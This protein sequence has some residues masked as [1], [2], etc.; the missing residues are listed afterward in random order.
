M[1]APLVQA[2][3]SLWAL[4]LAIPSATFSAEC[5][6]GVLGGR[7]RHAPTRDESAKTTILI[8]AHNESAGIGETLAKLSA[9]LRRS[10]QILVVAD[11]CTDDTAAK[12]RLAGA[13]VLERVDPERR[14]KGYALS[15]GVAHMASLPS[16]PNIVLVMDA[17]C[18]LSEGGIDALA[19]TALS[20]NR[21]AQAEYAMVIPEGADLKTKIGAF[22]FRVKNLIRPRALHCLGLGRQLAG[23]GMAFPWSVL[24]DAPDM[25]GHITEDLVL[26]LELALRG[27]A[28]VHCPD[29]LVESD[30]AP[31]VSGQAGQRKRWEQGH[32]LAIREYLPK[33]L[34]GALRQRRVEL[35]VLGC[36][37][38][39]PS[40]AI[41]VLMLG[42]TCA[43]TGALAAAWPA[44]GL[45]PFSIGC[46]DA[47]LVGCGVA[48]SWWA[49]GRDLLSVR[50]LC[51]GLPRYLLWK[52]PTYLHLVRHREE[53]EWVRA[54]R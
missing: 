34:E 47:A 30:I 6:L 49:C 9:Q 17:D 36:D 21:P 5:L 54:E 29:V 10:D 2:A 31:S 13:T 8:P 12:A 18:V 23:T 46:A 24:R 42:G 27:Q 35:F 48:A 7:R 32:L 43:A 28:T 41:L 22:A 39:V 4:G 45:V 20:T 40:L 50:E 33:M 53:A 16:P 44:V 38:A 37:L 3:L 11:N 25:K 52:V 26:G 14:G 51:L 1:I 19:A 15:Y